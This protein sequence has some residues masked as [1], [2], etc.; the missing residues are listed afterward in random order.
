MLYYS[1]R[2][3]MGPNRVVHMLLRV[4]SIR[5]VSEPSGACLHLSSRPYFL[6]KLHTSNNRI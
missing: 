5:E 1:K 4:L 6:S 3:N 2:K